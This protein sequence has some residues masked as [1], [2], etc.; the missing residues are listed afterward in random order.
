MICCCGL[1]EIRQTLDEIEIHYRPYKY[2]RQLLEMKEQE[3]AVKHI[4]Y[5]V[6]HKRDKKTLKRMLTEL[7]KSVETVQKSIQQI[8][9]D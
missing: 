8:E 1:F 7:S 3:E 4:Q 6:R 5:I 2:R 9:C